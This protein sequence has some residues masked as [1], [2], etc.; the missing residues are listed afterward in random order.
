MNSLSYCECCLLLRNLTGQNHSGQMCFSQQQLDLT[1]QFTSMRNIRPGMFT[2]GPWPCNAGYLLPHQGRFKKGGPCSTTAHC[3]KIIPGLKG[4]VK[5]IIEIIMPLSQL[6]G[7][8]DLL[9][10][11]SLKYV[12]SRDRV[13]GI[14]PGKGKTICVSGRQ[15]STD[16]KHLWLIIKQ[17]RAKRDLVENLLTFFKKI[18]KAEPGHHLPVE[19]TSVHIFSVTSRLT[20]KDWT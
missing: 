10:E 5:A 3:M 1:K 8:Y 12:T 7:L 6:T 19:W 13:N 9:A 18:L 2:R 4:L 15:L 11:F 17:D 14:S 16:E 20:Y